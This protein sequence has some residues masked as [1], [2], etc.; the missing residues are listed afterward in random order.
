MEPVSRESAA[1]PAPFSRYPQPIPDKPCRYS[2]FFPAW[3]WLL[4]SAMLLAS[5]AL[6]EAVGV[7]IVRSPGDLQAGAEFASSC[8]EGKALLPSQAP[9][10]PLAAVGG[11]QLPP[12]NH[13][14]HSSVLFSLSLHVLCHCCSGNSCQYLNDPH[15]CSRLDLENK[16][17]RY[18]LTVPTAQFC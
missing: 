10:R 15:A 14:C 7:W 8:T 6:K 3:L 1:A 4:S 9:A 17:S 11:L 16:G 12:S 18:L 5:A 2:W 13:V